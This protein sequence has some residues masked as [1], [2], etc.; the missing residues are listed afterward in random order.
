M[1]ELCLAYQ[2]YKDD[3]DIPSLLLIPCV[4]LDFLS[5]HPFSDGNGRVSRLLTLL[6]LYKEGYDIAK[7]ISFENQ[8]NNYKV[9]YYEALE[10]S[11]NQWHE[12]R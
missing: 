2:V 4:I 6:L 11:Q 5:I 10:K 1:K 12:N 9:N 8:I 7:Y 3:Y